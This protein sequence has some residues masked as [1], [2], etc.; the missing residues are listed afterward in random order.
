MFQKIDLAC[1]NW[2]NSGTKE[3]TVTFKSAFTTENGLELTEE[4]KTSHGI[5]AS[6]GTQLGNE[7]LTKLT[8]VIFE[9]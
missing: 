5:S 8:D 2:G 6:V 9:K 4:T 3:C 1:N 7:M